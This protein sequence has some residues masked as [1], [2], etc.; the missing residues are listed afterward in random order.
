M[1]DEF[2]K[3][4]NFILDCAI[5]D[6]TTLK[7]KIFNC[8]FDQ[9]KAIVEAVINVEQLTDCKAAHNLAKG[10]EKDISDAPEGLWR[11][12]LRENCAIL[13]TILANVAIP[14][15]QEEFLGVLCCENEDT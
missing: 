11:D 6:L 12:L 9:L 1:S 14:C 5:S 8:T 3:E 7:K 13:R 10:L 4:V 2:S 15:V